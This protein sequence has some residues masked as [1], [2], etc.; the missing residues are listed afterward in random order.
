MRLIPD[1]LRG[2]QGLMSEG[3]AALEAGE[4]RRARAIAR[5]LHA[6][7]Y[8]GAFEIE[9][10]A[11]GAEGR[12]EEACTAL[13]E[14]TKVAPKAWMLWVQLGIAESERGHFESALAAFDRARAM[15]GVDSELVALNTAETLARASRFE[16][17][18]EQ[19]DLS[20]SSD[21]RD[22]V[23]A[24]RASIL[25]R[26]GRIADLEKLAAALPGDIGTDAGG[27]IAGSLLAA[28]HRAGRSEGELRARALGLPRTTRRHPRVLWMLRELSGP[29]GGLRV[30]RLTVVA[31]ASHVA[32][33]VPA[34]PGGSVAGAYIVATIAA[35]T[36]QQAHSLLCEFE[37]SQTLAFESAEDA[38]EQPPT[39]PGIYWVSGLTIF[40]GER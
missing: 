11:L 30:W 15:E 10:R 25:E 8:S 14:A 4:L 31:D 39:H 38:T 13:V 22:E 17:A 9:A 24:L 35:P 5:V 2:T 32:A 37:G 27:A 7:R 26:S 29:A 34:S 21:R 6:R 33:H 12:W 16:E 19:A 18:L 28:L 40:T 23:F 1:F 36:P 3:R 20:C